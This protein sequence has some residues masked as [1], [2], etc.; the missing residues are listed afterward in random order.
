MRTEDGGGSSSSTQ[1]T[2]LE[3]DY[4]TNAAANAA[5]LGI[6]SVGGVVA[7]VAGGADIEF[8][9]EGI[10]QMIQYFEKVRDE[11]M[12]DA[13]TKAQ[14]LQWFHGADHPEAQAY[15]QSVTKLGD[16]YMAY[17]KKLSDAV[18]KTIAALKK[19]KHEYKTNEDVHA[20]A[21]SHAAGD[22]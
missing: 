10:D 14:Y 22:M 16:N 5:A 20:K 15:A 2:Q 6:G 19:A 12:E 17:H 7:A 4:M 11:E 13:K 8:N 3:Q 9:E 21:A 1:L 18:E